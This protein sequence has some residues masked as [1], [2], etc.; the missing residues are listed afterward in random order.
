MDQIKK[1]R[2]EF[3]KQ[4][5][6]I[7]TNKHQKV[8]QILVEIEKYQTLKEDFERE[9]RAKLVLLE[10]INH[11]IDFEKNDVITSILKLSGLNKYLRQNC[12]QQTSSNLQIEL[13]RLVGETIKNNLVLQN[14]IQSLG[15]IQQEES[16]N[17][18]LLRKITRSKIN[19]RNILARIKEK[20]LFSQYLE[21]LP[22]REARN[23]II[24]HREEFGLQCF[25][26][27]LQHIQELMHNSKIKK[28]TAW[29]EL[30][31]IA[32]KLQ[33]TLCSSSC[34]KDDQAG[35]R[36]A[37]GLVG[38]MITGGH[39]ESA[40]GNDIASQAAGF[41]ARSYN[42]RPEL[43]MQEQIAKSLQN[44]K[45][46]SYDKFNIKNPEFVGIYIDL[47]NLEQNLIDTE[48][49]IKL[50]NQIKVK[51]KNLNIPYFYLS[52]GLFYD[53]FDKIIDPLNLTTTK[54]TTLAEKTE[55]VDNHS[56]KFFW[57]NN[58]KK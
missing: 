30:L 38:L 21:D 6:E 19:Q 18:Q 46:N 4:I 15:Q 7:K 48:A 51:A 42:S 50:M 53:E 23:V 16:Q 40:A 9:I 20:S 17:I 56:G 41:Y 25:I 31:E 36:W 49:R 32:V 45:N 10:I 58:E 55:F 52:Q 27:S 8:I 14:L 12:S 28:G 5:Q 43:L 11:R 24:K 44:R 54:P 29:S 37:G 39:I 2:Q 3:Q 47:D 13:D 34:R 1:I 35:N 22:Q 57:E 33:P 26:H